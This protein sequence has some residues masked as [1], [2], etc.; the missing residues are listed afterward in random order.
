MQCIERFALSHT[1]AELFAEAFR[2]R[3]LLVPISSGTELALSA[4]T[5]S[6]GCPSRL[7]PSTTGI[8][9]GPFP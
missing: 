5:G 2:R 3:I 4:A 8:S 7:W 6:K 9:R 1:K